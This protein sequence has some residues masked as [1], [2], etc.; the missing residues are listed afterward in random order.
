MSD[1]G[2]SAGSTPAGWRARLRSARAALVTSA[3]LAVGCLAFTDAPLWAVLLGEA[4]MVLAILA[5]RAPRPQAL[6]VRAART[7]SPWPDAHLRSLIDALPEPCFL[8]DGEGRL[9][10]QNTAA[11]ERF[12][13]PR[14]GDPVSF[15]LR[16]PEL[17]AA[18]DQAQHGGTPQPVRYT[19]RSP[20][21]RSWLGF[22]SPLRV[23]RAE[24][25]APARIDWVL[26]RL[27]DETDQ[28]RLER[29]RADFVANASH[30]LRTPL[31]SLTGFIETLLGPARDDAVNRERFLKIMQEQAGRMARLIDDLTSLSRIEARAHVRPGTTVDLATTVRSALDG[32]APVV[33]ENRAMLD[34][35]GIPERAAV[36]G[37]RDELIQVAI[38]L[39]E[40]GLKYGREGGRVEVSI[41]PEPGPEGGA[42]WVLS[43]RDDGPG[44]D[45]EHL[46]RLTER[47]YRVDADR[48]RRQKGTGLGLA[49]V[50]HIVNRHRGRLSIRSQPGD[51][52]TFSVWLPAAPD[53][54]DGALRPAGGPLE[55][56]GE[57]PSN[58]L[59][60]RLP[61]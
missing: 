5:V 9:R 16:S 41:A 32:L 36:V 18:V 38:N 26:V 48:S 11:A 39:V 10:Y 60:G 21:E 14:L 42:G 45:P 30:E 19:E 25:R 1:A 47:F 40:N 28:L 59:P 17:L 37:D 12:G 6:G 34:L 52:A 31:A 35:T 44:I 49:I 23:P 7:R 58:A 3:V 8:T 29:M 50:K 46:P 55:R 15:K 24:P 2:G 61:E 13:A 51:G 33:A 54:A 4:A 56:S 53:E 22:V 27:M 43:V 57:D 20:T